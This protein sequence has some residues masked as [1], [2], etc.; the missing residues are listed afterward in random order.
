MSKHLFSGC[1][2]IQSFFW[3]FDV[4][5]IWVFVFCYGIHIL[6]QL[7]SSKSV[8][9]KGSYAQRRSSSPICLASIKFK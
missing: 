1:S 2:V 6:Q 7:P 4:L 3:L 9:K 8:R 5:E